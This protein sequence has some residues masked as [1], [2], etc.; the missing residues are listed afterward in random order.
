MLIDFWRQFPYIT[1]RVEIIYHLWDLCIPQLTIIP[2]S[3]E[4]MHFQYIT[5]IHSRDENE[6]KHLRNEKKKK[7]NEKEINIEQNKE[8]NKWSKTHACKHANKHQ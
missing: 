2:T 4:V 7:K 6:T 1:L 8:G 3:V 5:N